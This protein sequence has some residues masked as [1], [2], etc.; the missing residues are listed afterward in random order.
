M[1]QIILDT[2]VNKKN[3]NELWYL[4]GIY[5]HLGYQA[6]FHTLLHTSICRFHMYWCIAGYREIQ[7]NIHQYLYMFCHHPSAGI[8]A[9]ICTGEKK[10]EH[11]YIHFELLA[12]SV[13]FWTC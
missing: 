12:D 3:N 6:V 8:Q 13:I 4:K 9:S 1:S 11:K 5:S 7:M 10:K 2:A